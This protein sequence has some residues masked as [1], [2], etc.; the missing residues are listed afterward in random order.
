MAK[1]DEYKHPKWQEMRLKVMERDG[2]RCNICIDKE[3]PLHV[4]HK[5][6]PKNKKIWEVHPDDLETLCESCHKDVESFVSFA[7]ERGASL[8][9]LFERV[10][11]IGKPEDMLKMLEDSCSDELSGEIEGAVAS[12]IAV[13][14]LAY[15]IKGVK[16]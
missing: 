3:A 12:A 8:I 7:R 13:L 16:E 15:E 1:I 11:G 5:K 2:F 10:I 9:L 6:Y 4:H 14:R